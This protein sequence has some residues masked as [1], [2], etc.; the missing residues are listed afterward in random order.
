MILPAVTELPAA[1]S[2]ISPGKSKQENLSPKPASSE[3]NLDLKRK[4]SIPK[5]VKQTHSNASS[6]GSSSRLRDVLS[7]RPVLSFP[8]D[9]EHVPLP[10]SSEMRNGSSE[11]NGPTNS[12]E[13]DLTNIRKL[14][15]GVS[16]LID[17]EPGE[18]DTLSRHL[19]GV[20]RE[21][22][23][24]QNLLQSGL[25]IIVYF[26]IIVLEIQVPSRF[27]VKTPLHN[28]SWSPMLIALSVLQKSQVYFRHILQMLNNLDIK[29]SPLYLLLIGDRD[30]E[31]S[32]MQRLLV[33]VNRKDAI[34]RRQFQ[35]DL[36]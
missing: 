36:V 3:P 35:V 20:Q 24:I 14:R 34:E 12:E 2:Q 10:P 26:I 29:Y 5:L 1:E 8:A 16:M 4:P 22:A 13:S 17:A 32:L 33:L 18:Q 23:E 11:V 27:I 21:I 31:K 6:S 9:I 15:S 28:I 30:M 19:A 25:F 7:S